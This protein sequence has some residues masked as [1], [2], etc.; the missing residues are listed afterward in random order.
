MPKHATA[1]TTRTAAPRRGSVERGA[2]LLAP[3]ELLAS[4]ETGLQYLVERLIGEGGFGQVYL[5]RRIGRFR[6]VNYA[7]LAY[8]AVSAEDAALARQ[9]LQEAGEA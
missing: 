6:M 9:V 2:L 1:A 4:P 7:S 3:A 5:A 8:L